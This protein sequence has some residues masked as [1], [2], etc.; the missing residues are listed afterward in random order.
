MSESIPE[1]AA[2]SYLAE[3]RRRHGYMRFLGLP[4][5]RDTPDVDI[6]RLYVPPAVSGQLISPDSEPG[7]WPATES[8]LDALEKNRRLIL[9]GDP[10]SGKSTLTNWLA[11]R[12][13]AGLSQRLPDWLE[14]LLPLTFVLREV[15]LRGVHTFDALLDALLGLPVA[16]ALVGSREALLAQIRAGKVLFLLDGLDEV[17]H[18]ERAKLRSAVWDGWRRYPKCYWLLTS[19]VVGYEEVPFSFEGLRRA[20]A[21]R[22]T[23]K[24]A[25]SSPEI[26]RKMGLSAAAALQSDLFLESDQDTAATIPIDYRSHLF[27]DLRDKR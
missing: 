5:L 4:Y 23:G 15:P 1:T 25:S 17:R 10:G 8:P 9:L 27:Y 18:S 21:T 6:S 3:V 26:V 20:M 19:R 11:W 16:R 12:L 22:H 13:S 7:N 2:R 24:G 14:G